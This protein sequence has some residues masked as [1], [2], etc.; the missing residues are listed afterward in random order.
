MSSKYVDQARLERRALQEYDFDDRLDDR[1]VLVAGGGGGLGAAVCARLLAGGADVVLGYADDE[2]RA[3]ALKDRLEQKYGGRVRPLRADIATDEGRVAVLE[4]VDGQSLYGAV[5]CVG[6]PARVAPDE[7]DIASLE[8]AMRLNYTGPILLARGCAEILARHGTAGALVL[9]S[10]MQ[11]V[12]AFPGSLAYSGPKAALVHAAR[13][14]AQEYGGARNIRV[15]VVAPGVT[16]SGMALASI[17][18]GK[19]DPYVDGGVIPRFGYPEDVARAVWF[20][21]TPDN[22]VT[23]QTLLVDGGLTLRRGTV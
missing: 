3:G 16:E 14:L 18:S 17:G 5:V 9:L 2:E 10:S 13:I 4:E 7:L 20:L 1:T 22:Y 19:Y 21:M 23:G 6:D 12:A 8:R 11:G 15:N